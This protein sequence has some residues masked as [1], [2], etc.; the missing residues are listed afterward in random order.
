MAMIN[1][2]AG[3]DTHNGPPQEGIINGHQG[4]DVPRGRKGNDVLYGGAGNDLLDG[5]AGADRAS[6]LSA[7]TG[8]VIDLTLG[9][10]LQ[11][12]LGAGLD[13]LG[14]IENLRGSEFDDRLFGNADDNLLDGGAGD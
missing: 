7:T 10:Q 14:G 9:G 4:D 5:G 3:N 13:T 6:Y 8:V 11:D 2:G 12:T 1:G